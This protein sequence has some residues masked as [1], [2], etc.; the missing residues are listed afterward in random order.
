MIGMSRFFIRFLSAVA[1]ALFLLVPASRASQTQRAPKKKEKLLKKQVLHFD[2]G[3]VFQTK[4]ALSELHAF[5]LMGRA[6]EADIFYPL[7]L[8]H[9]LTVK[10]YLTIHIHIQH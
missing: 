8:N 1:A 7:N 9:N 3:I 2:G 4:R 6:T 5:P 10:T